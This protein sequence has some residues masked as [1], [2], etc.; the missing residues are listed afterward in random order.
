M[1]KISPD[2]ALKCKDV[3]FVDTRSP[4]EYA[5]DRIPGAIN[6]PLLDNEE[7][8]QVGIT[9]KEDKEKAFELGME[10]YAKKLPRLTQEIRELDP[11]KTVV[12]Y[13]WRGGMRSKAITQLVDLMGYTTY[14]LEGGY[15][16]YRAHVREF[17]ENND[18]PFDF[19]VL[20]GKAGC[21]KTDLI[22]ELPVSIDLE[23]YAQHRSSVF[24]AIGLTPNSQKRCESL[25]YKRIRELEHEPYV[26]IEGESR[27]I[28]DLFVPDRFF[29]RMREG[30]AVYVESSIE[31]RAERI[32]RDYFTHGEDERIKEIIFSLKQSLTKKRAQELCD[33][34]DER[35]YHDVAR[36]L[37]EEYYDARYSYLLESLTYSHT[38]CSDDQENALEQLRKLRE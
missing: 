19:I 36:A 31:R 26:F 8:K 9:Y 14:Q 38:I 27:K 15:K 29:K 12:V 28:G 13:C 7:R 21:G 25:L 6:L 20:Y 37:L 33:L 3:C 1:T 17:F 5:H 2:D 10:Y 4:A 23:G 30:I 34:V 16:A 11:A 18:P 32:V 24:G 35:R 22:N